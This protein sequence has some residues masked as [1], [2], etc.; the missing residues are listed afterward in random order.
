[1]HTDLSLLFRYVLLAVILLA[2]V[3]NVCLGAYLLYQFFASPRRGRPT[4]HWT[5]L[6]GVG[7]LLFLAGIPTIFMGGI[8]LIFA[9]TG[10]WAF[11]AWRCWRGV[12]PGGAVVTETHTGG[13]WPPPPDNPSA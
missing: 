8:L 5:G 7:L 9:S 3:G 2:A 4:G 12:R 10:V 1:M 11:A 6:W 13:V